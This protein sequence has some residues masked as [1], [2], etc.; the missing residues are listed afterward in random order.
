MHMELSAQFCSVNLSR[1]FFL[2]TSPIL[3]VLIFQQN[4]DG[5]DQS[6]NDFYLEIQ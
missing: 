4:K 2:M 6:T 3:Q 5:G 1:M